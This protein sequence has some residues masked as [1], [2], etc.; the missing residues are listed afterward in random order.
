MKLKNLFLTLLALPLFFVACEPTAE[1]VDEVKDATV[2]ITAG[3]ATNE[4]ISFTIASTDA[5]KVAYIVVEGEEAPTA[6][7]VLANGTQIEANK[8]VEVTASELKAETLYTIVAAA[9]NSKG[10]RKSVV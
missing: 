9:Q 1:K 5:V 7:E 10:D 4:A 6:S 3:T 8:S 2:A